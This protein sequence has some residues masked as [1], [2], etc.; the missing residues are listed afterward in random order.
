MGV[1][2]TKQQ[3]YGTFKTPSKSRWTC[4][5]ALTVMLLLQVIRL[6]LSQQLDWSDC[7]DS[8]RLQSLGWLRGSTVVSRFKSNSECYVVQGSQ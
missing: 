5:T 7:N 3:I 1:L 8:Q 6:S 4:V 2:A